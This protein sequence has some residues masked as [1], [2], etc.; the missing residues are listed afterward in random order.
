MQVRDFCTTEMFSPGGPIGGETS[1]SRVGVCSCILLP[2]VTDSV[3]SYKRTLRTSC[4]ISLLST[5]V[6]FILSRT[7][8]EEI[9]LRV[10]CHEPQCSCVL[11][12]PAG[13]V[14]R[15]G[16]ER[17]LRLRVSVV[18][19]R[20]PPAHR[21]ALSLGHRRRRGHDRHHHR[22][23]LRQASSRKSVQSVCTRVFLCCVSNP[24]WC[25]QCNAEY[26]NTMRSSRAHKAAAG[27]D[28]YSYVCTTDR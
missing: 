17:R 20:H 22:L 12:E 8:G 6:L 15:R 9:C 26:E 27:G 14:D 2:D 18:L 24:F 21:P 23:P 28:T 19:G 13:R 1:V 7:L 11:P 25:A 10:L 3:L 4:G 5:R 16:P